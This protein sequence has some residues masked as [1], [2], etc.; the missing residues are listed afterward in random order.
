M[1]GSRR[2][3]QKVAAQLT[4]STPGPEG[5][6]TVA[7]LLRLWQDLKRDRWTAST[8]RNQASRAKL[9]AAGPL[10]ARQVD[11]LRVED[12]D[13]W[14]LGI[15]ADGVGTA[16][17]HNQL[18]VLRAALAQAVKWDWIPRNP[19]A[20]ATPAS[21]PPAVRSSMPVEA[22]LAVIRSAPHQAAALAFRLAAVTG[23]RRAELAALQWED[24]HAPTLV[25][26]GQIVAYPS[27]APHRPPV[28][29]RE[30]T[31][32]RQVRTVTLDPGTLR[33]I[34][35]WRST[36]RGLGP[37]LLAVGERPPSPDAIG[38]WWRH[39]RAAAGIDTKW[40]LHDLRHWSATTAIGI[41]ADVRTVANR[42]GHSNPGLT[43]KVYAHAF[44]AADASAAAALGRV[45]DGSDEEHRDLDV[46][47]ATVKPS[48]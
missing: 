38:W 12:I 1:R 36:H 23:A 31:K 33:A 44:A 8:A 10:G 22:V 30:P 4:V 43:L 28:L 13:R 32:T 17:I 5:R 29:V 41:G 16:S 3:A 24:L 9:I 6:R 47:P 37:W 18:M 35:E 25:I 39:A 11:S 21:H 45:L 48:M 27:D 40:R 20:L 19:A 2:A 26:A 46:H 42:L 15:R 34:H 7:E 14:V